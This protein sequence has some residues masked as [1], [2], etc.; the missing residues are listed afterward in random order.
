MRLTDVTLPA[1]QVDRPGQIWPQSWPG[2]NL[3]AA[4]HVLTDKQIQFVSGYLN[5]ESSLHHV[6]VSL[7]SPFTPTIIVAVHILLLHLTHTHTF[8]HPP[9]LLITVEG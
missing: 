3:D 2:L 6:P 1:M 9:W 5:V 8:T 4:E 7:F